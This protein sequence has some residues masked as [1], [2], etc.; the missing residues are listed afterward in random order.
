[1][2]MWADLPQYEEYGSREGSVEI[3]E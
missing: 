1:M 2:I 3:D